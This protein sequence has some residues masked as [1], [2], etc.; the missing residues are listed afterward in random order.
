MMPIAR[1]DTTMEGSSD[2]PSP[3]SPE[4]PD[5]RK[6]SATESFSSSP[7]QRSPYG[8]FGNGGASGHITLDDPSPGRLRPPMP[9]RKKTT[10]Q[11]AR[12]LSEAMRLA[13]SR[14]EQEQ[15]LGDEEEADDDGCYPPRRNSDPR[16]PNPHSH[17]PVYQTIHRI[18]RLVIAS[19]DDPYT[20]DQLK[21]PRMNVS[22]VRPLVDH[23]YD[24]EDV[25]IGRPSFY[26][27]H[28][29]V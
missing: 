13:R 7:G 22:V 21:S 1:Q 23:L 3:S 15:L 25:S 20:L 14:E 19:I 12:S 29:V 4:P 16:V 6:L 11:S 17:L 28:M 5:L 2:H 26:S 27:S 10:E 8:T 24:P 18:R 9:D